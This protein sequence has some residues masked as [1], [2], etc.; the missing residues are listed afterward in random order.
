MNVTCNKSSAT[1]S[2]RKERK[3]NPCTRGATRANSF[4]K[5]RAS[6]ATYADISSSSVGPIQALRQSRR[7]GY[8]IEAE[9]AGMNPFVLA[10]AVFVVDGDADAPQLLLDLGTG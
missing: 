5:A 3:K 8:A 7:G 9:D 2:S 6:P 4:S 1:P 10:A